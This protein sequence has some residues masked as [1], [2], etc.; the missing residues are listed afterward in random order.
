MRRVFTPVV[1][2]AAI[3]AVSGL[4]FASPLPARPAS[5]VLVTATEAATP[6]K[7]LKATGA[8]KAATG[9][10]LTLKVKEADKVFAIDSKT[11]ITEHGKKVAASDLRKAVG[12]HATVRYEEV[13][14]TMTATTVTI[15]KPGDG[16]KSAKK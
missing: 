9:T 7:P 15:A 4:L 13:S 12:K 1:A 8:I 2:A 10:E 14:G 11:V 3:A 5:S 6:A 16:K